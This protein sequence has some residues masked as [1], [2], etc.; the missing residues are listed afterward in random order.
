MRFP[1]V[2][3]RVCFFL[4]SVAVLLIPL[5]IVMED[6]RGVV[7]LCVVSIKL[8]LCGLIFRELSKGLTR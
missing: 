7:V 8:A 3:S 2:A 6:P 4:T 1:S 5:V